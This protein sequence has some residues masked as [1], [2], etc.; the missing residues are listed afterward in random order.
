MNNVVKSVFCLDV[1]SVYCFIVKN[2][3][4]V[5]GKFIEDRGKTI[6]ILGDLGIE[7]ILKDSIYFYY[8]IKEN[9]VFAD[10]FIAS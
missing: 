3:K 5:Y 9:K 8:K 7:E 4:E 10:K 6:A 2:E 1:N